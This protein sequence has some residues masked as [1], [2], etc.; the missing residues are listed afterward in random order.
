[1][2]IPDYPLLMWSLSQR[3]TSLWG[4]LWKRAYKELFL[5][6]CE[7]QTLSSSWFIFF[8]RE[9]G[10]SILCSYDCE[11]GDEAKQKVPWQ[12]L[13]YF[14]SSFNTFQDTR[15]SFQRNTC[16]HITYGTS[17]ATGHVHISC[18][19]VQ[20]LSKL[21][22]HPPKVLWQLCTQSHRTDVLGTTKNEA[23][24]IFSREC[25]ENFYLQQF[26]RLLFPH[27]LFDKL[28]SIYSQH[29]L[30]PPPSPQPTGFFFSP[31]DNVTIWFYYSEIPQHV[32]QQSWKIIRCCCGVKAHLWSMASSGNY[33]IK[34][35][36]TFFCLSTFSLSFSAPPGPP[37]VL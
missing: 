9:C 37:K 20:L 4:A 5:W 28:F 33:G 3:S 34:C 32:L 10:A 11:A 22:C 17:R 2:D 14:C 30:M 24:G 19:A 18:L 12:S 25:E 16:P 15:R 23:L 27:S 8:G 35:P 7:S 13:L 6:A 26:T 29:I 31:S 1:M 21:L 36:K